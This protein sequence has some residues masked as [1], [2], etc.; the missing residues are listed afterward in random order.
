LI[1]DEESENTLFEM[2]FEGCPILGVW[3]GAEEK[4]SNRV[5]MLARVLLNRIT[6]ARYTFD[7]NPGRMKLNPEKYTDDCEDESDPGHSTSPPEVNPDDA[8]AGTQTN[9]LRRFLIS[10]LNGSHS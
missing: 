4:V 9:R 10:F 2:D 1:R 3:S 7:N 6:P 5:E 8:A